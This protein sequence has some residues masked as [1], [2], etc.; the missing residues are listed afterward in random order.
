MMACIRRKRWRVVATAAAVVGALASAGCAGRGTP[1]LGAADAQQGL[2]AYR[3]GAGDRLRI[4][5]YAEPSLSGDYAVSGA[6]E[7][8][9]PLIGTVAAGGRTLAE[10]TEVLTARLGDG[11]M[12]APRVSIE[13]LQY[14]P[15]Y[16]LGEVEKPGEYPYVAG[17]TIEQ[18]VAAAGG[19]SY[20]ANPRRVI[21][22]RLP[23][24]AEKAVDLQSGQLVAVMPGDTIRVL[25][26]YF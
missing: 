18:A 7:I 22:R 4:G 17:R 1:P 13:V 11:Y 2:Q 21:L 23:D 8:A 12:L 3:L 16:I 24:P 14:R 15:Y 19:F 20:R 10:V 9:F 26:R 5:V 6:G 25:E